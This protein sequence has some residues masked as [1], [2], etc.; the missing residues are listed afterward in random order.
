MNSYF[1]NLYGMARSTAIRHIR[2]LRDE[3]KRKNEGGAMQPIYLRG[4]GYYTN[5]E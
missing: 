2:H 1:Q 4:S 3:E 5:S